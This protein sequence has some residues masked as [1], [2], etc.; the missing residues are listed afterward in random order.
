[1]RASKIRA[2]LK[3]G[4]GLQVE[5]K[6]CNSELSKSAFETI[7]AFLN[8]SGGELLLGINN[9]GSVVG[10]RA[11]SI[12]KIRNNFTTLMNNPEKINPPFYLSIE[13]VIIEDKTIFYIYVPE[14]SQ[15][16]RCNNKIFDRNDDGDFDITNNQRLVSALYLRK[17]MSYSENKVFPYVELADLRQDIMAQVKT[18]ALNQNSMHPWQRMDDFELIKS[19]QL[20]G[21]DYQTGKEGITLVGVLLFGKDNT[22]LSVIPHFKTDAILRRIDVDRYDDRDIVCTNL[23]DSFDRL[24]HFGEKYLND[25]FYLEGSQRISLRNL[26]LREVVSNLLIHR[27]FTNPFPAKMVIDRESFYTENSNKSH[28]TGIIDPS[29]FSPYPKNPIIARVFREIGRADELGSGVRKLFKYCKAFCGSDPELIEN[30]IFKFILPLKT[31]M[32][33]QVTGQVTKQVLLFCQKPRKAIEIQTLLGLKHRETFQD[34]YLKPLLNQKLIALTIPDKPRSSAQQ[35]IITELGK[36]LL[37][38]N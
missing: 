15:V 31:Q 38:G 29:N 30:D 1:M 34:N 27:E 3:Q 20:F 32:T 13:E 11:E 22:I 4:E 7:C 25:P 19:A 33:G 8:R 35:Y 10:I 16:H 14:S 26:I 21:K 23:I 12:E 2:I 28:N 6:E 9:K 17:Q 36:S 37:K 24:L 5:F 18:M